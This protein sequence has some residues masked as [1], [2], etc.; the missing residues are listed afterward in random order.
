MLYDP[1]LTNKTIKAINV[2]TFRTIKVALKHNQRNQKHYVCFVLRE[3]CLSGTFL[4]NSQN[5]N[6]SERCQTTGKG[7]LILFAVDG[8]VKQLMD[9]GFK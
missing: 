6:C 1:K 3:Q 9:N 2:I 7:K 5:T 8:V 4:I